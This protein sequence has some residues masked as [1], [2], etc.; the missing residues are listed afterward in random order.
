MKFLPSEILTLKKIILEYN[1]KNK[2]S[3]QYLSS[4][5]GISRPSLRKIANGELTFLYY[6]TLNKILNLDGLSL[7]SK[8]EIQ[9]II[10]KY[11]KNKFIEENY[12]IENIQLNNLKELLLTV[13]DRLDKTD[14]RMSQI[15]DSIVKTLLVQTEIL[16]KQKKTNTA[17]EYMQVRSFTSDFSI[18]ARAINLLFKLKTTPSEYYSELML[19]LS[20]NSFKSNQRISKGIKEKAEEFINMGNSLLKTLEKENEIAELI[21]EG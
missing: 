11:Y 16:T 18:T 6:E 4:I 9:K 15:K 1:K 17:N 19:L 2:Y 21:M 12:L 3:Q 5:S 7:N 10:L 13:S 14:E 8:N 20:A